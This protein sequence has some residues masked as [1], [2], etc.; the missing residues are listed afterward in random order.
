M[1]TFC[2]ANKVKEDKKNL[3]VQEDITIFLKTI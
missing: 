2:K 3:K 1:I